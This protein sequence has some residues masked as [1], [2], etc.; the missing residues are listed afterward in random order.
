VTT[1][2]IDDTL[3]IVATDLVDLDPAE[4]THLPSARRRV[5]ALTAVRPA[6]LPNLAH[7]ADVVVLLPANDV[8]AAGSKALAASA[9]RAA[10]R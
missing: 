3:V 10:I 9:L 5:L 2:V 4:L 7:I 8:E 1:S 6:D